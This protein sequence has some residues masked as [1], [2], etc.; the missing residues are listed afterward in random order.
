MAAFG[1]LASLAFGTPSQAGMVN[2]S[3]GFADY[4]NTPFANTISQ[5]TFQFSGLD[6]ITGASFSGSALANSPLASATVTVTPNA[7]A[8]TIVLTFAPTSI[9]NVTGSLSFNTLET[10]SASIKLTSITVVSSADVQ[11]HTPISVAAVPEPAS[12]GLLGIGMAGF[13]AFRR[14]SRKRATK[15]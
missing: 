5:V 2:V 12:M 9:F 6:G 13:F 15:V 14:F 10:P 7:A 4:N 3:L 11:T 1:L 8:E